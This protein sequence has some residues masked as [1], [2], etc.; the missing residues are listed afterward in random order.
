MGLIG[1][2]FEAGQFLSFS[3][4]SLSGHIY[5][6]SEVTFLPRAILITYIKSL[7]GQFCVLCGGLLH[8]MHLLSVVDFFALDRV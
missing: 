8:P 5:F 2:Y 3:P 4:P 6:D 1:C 7:A